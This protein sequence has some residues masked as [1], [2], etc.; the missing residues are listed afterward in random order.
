MPRWR[1][2]NHFNQVMSISFSDASKFEDLSKVWW[3]FS[4]QNLLIIL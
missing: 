3:T 2:L 4:R 1:D